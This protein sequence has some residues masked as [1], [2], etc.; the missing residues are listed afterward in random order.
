MSCCSLGPFDS[1]SLLDRHDVVGSSFAETL[2]ME[3]LDELGQWQFPRLLPVVFDLAQF[4]RVQPKLP[5]L[6]YLAVRQMGK[7]CEVQAKSVKTVSPSPLAGTNLFPSQS[8]G[9]MSFRV[10]RIGLGE[11]FPLV[12]R[13][14]GMGKNQARV[15]QL[16][17]QFRMLLRKEF[18]SPGFVGL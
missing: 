15:L 5:G 12:S 3:L 7:N 9:T 16:A 2:A 13:V 6:L 10:S 4:R 14:P 17:Q 1:T 8:S 18:E 11:D